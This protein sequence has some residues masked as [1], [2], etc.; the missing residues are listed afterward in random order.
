MNNLE[1][2]LLI[3]CAIASTLSLMWLAIVASSLGLRVIEA[4]HHMRRI[5]DQ[6]DR[7]ELVDVTQC[8]SSR[9]PMAEGPI[10]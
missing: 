6:G 10:V 1:H 8:E 7:V 2:G 5:A 4:V 9:Q 3:A